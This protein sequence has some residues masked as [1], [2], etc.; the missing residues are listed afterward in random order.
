MNDFDRHLSA[1]QGW[2]ELGCPEEAWA[3]I[4]EIEPT[5][6]AE[7]PVLGLRL[8][9]CQELKRWATM[10]EVC[11]HLAGVQPEEVQWAVS[12]AYATRRAEGIEAAR[13]ILGRALKRFPLEAVIHFNLACY[14]AQTGEITSA[15]ALL[16]SACSLEPGWLAKALEDP[17]LAPLWPELGRG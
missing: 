2:L 4:E 11:R 1:A 12:L 10:V 13:V 6:R 15:R 3:E 14:A 5:R 17:D 9:L 7:V 16:H 8:L